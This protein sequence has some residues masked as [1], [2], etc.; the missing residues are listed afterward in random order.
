MRYI[1]GAGGHARV[2]LSIC[3]SASLHIDGFIEGECTKTSFAGLPCYSSDDVPL[4]AT[5]EVL[6]AIGSNQV[7][8]D[9]SKQVS[10]NFF[11]A[12]HPSAIIDRSV[13]FGKGVMVCPNVVIN[14]EAQI[15]DHVILN[16]SSV[17]EH[18][19]IVED[20]V[21]IS[22]NATLCGS[23]RVGA[24]SHIGSGAVLIPGIQIGSGCVIGAGAVVIR[25]VPDNSMVV[26]N[27]ARLIK[28]VHS[29]M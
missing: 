29:F 26:G 19:C 3:E 7:R 9:I 12:I 5:D 18:H 6:I 14:P 15:G 2:V 16:T 1:F 20:Y 24:G 11:N 4:S 8:K 22:P 13:I 21:H 10:S 28:T 27:P 25:D 23:V 17:I